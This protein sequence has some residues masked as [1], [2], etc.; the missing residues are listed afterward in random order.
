M[1]LAKTI[2]VLCP[3]SFFY[4]MLDI[5][6]FAIVLTCSK[7][8]GLLCFLSQQTVTP[9]KQWG[10]G[11]PGTFEKSFSFLFQWHSH[12]T[13]IDRMMV[14]AVLV[15]QG[16][17]GAI[18]CTELFRTATYMRVSTLSC[19]FY[20]Q[21]SSHPKV[22]WIRQLQINLVNWGLC[23]LLNNQ[24]S[25]F[26]LTQH[27]VIFLFPSSFFRGLLGVKNLVLPKDKWRRQKQVYLG[28]LSVRGFL[29]LDA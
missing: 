11:L 22:A 29:D 5:W 9:G 15:L 8:G 18:L 19:H 2:L 27:Q 21:M 26:F 24:C 23:L 17:A 13:V 4:L 20:I 12:E 10:G 16:Q 25:F 7:A 28:G 3:A 14:R 1:L 6:T